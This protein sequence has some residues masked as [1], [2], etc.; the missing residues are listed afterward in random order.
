[1][2]T[3]VGELNSDGAKWHWFLLHMFLALPLTN[4]LSQVITG[5]AFSGWICLCCEP[6]NLVVF[7]F[8]GVKGGLQHQL[9]PG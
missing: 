9:C 5:L 1:M 4:W 2:L 6:V 7:E 3:M 8:L